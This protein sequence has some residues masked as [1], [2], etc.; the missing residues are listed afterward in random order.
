MGS[1]AQ[2]FPLLGEFRGRSPQRGAEPRD[3]QEL[4]RRAY[5]SLREL[6]ARLGDRHPLVISIDDLQWGDVDSAGLLTELLRLPDA[7]V[8]LLLATYRD[9]E[10]ET[11]P[12]MRSFL[13]DELACRP[14]FRAIRVDPLG[15][16][17]AQEL[18]AALLRSSVAGAPA[19]ATAIASESGG[20][21]F[22]IDELVRFAE[23][24]E[25]GI[26][27]TGVPSRAADTDAREATLAHMI[28]L[29]LL[30]LPT[31]AQRLL[32][33]AAVNGRPVPE[34]VL[35]SA[36]DVSAPESALALLRAEHLL[37]ARETERGV[38]LEPYHDRIRELVVRS[39]DPGELREC[40][41]RLATA[42]QHPG[43]ADPELLGEHF[44][45]AGDI[46]RAAEHL[47]IAGQQ[48]E[49]ALAFDRAARLYRR[50]L[51]LL[52]PASDQFA[53][54]M[55]K[56]G[57]ALTNAGRCAEAAAVYLA[58]PT[59]TAAE[60]I[61]FK[62]KAAQQLL[63][64]GHV[65]EGLAVV[66]EVLGSIGM[67][68]PQGR[69]QTLAALI[70][71][72]LRVRIRGLR[73]AERATTPA[74][75]DE[76]MKVDACWSVSAGLG[77]VDTMR[78]AVFQTRHL[79]LALR[80]GE[81]ARV[82]RAL[83]MEAMFAATAGVRTI[84]R[85][86]RIRSKSRD[87]TAKVGTPYARAMQLL[88][89]GVSAY[90]VGNWKP[91]AASIV[92]AERLLTNDCT[93]VTWE[94]DCARFFGLYALYQLGE[95]KTIV[96][97]LPVL[98]KDAH[99]RGDLYASTT[100]GGFFAHLTYL[101]TDDPLGASRHT[102]EA[103]RHWAQRDF[104]MPHVW[105]LWSSADIAMYEGRGLDAY[106]QVRDTWPALD[107]SLLLNVQFMRIS[108]LDLKGRAALSAATEA[109]RA[110]DRERFCL[111][112]RKCAR[113]MEQQRVEWAAG[114]ALMLRAGVH[115]LRLEPAAAVAALG[116][117]HETFRARDMNLL[118][119]VARRRRGEMTG[120]GQGTAHITE[121]DAW[122][123][124][125]DIRE[126]ASFTRIFAPAGG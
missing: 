49:Q 48:A 81:L 51:T 43:S 72:R 60:A 61:D 26:A 54:C 69:W 106:T 57:R 47:L 120:G 29:R 6:L 34:S 118:A 50:T 35:V 37:R 56:H 109:A 17:E 44:F 107:H 27:G 113:T 75:S 20:S 8:L 116:R 82:H 92:D 74:S 80:A 104:H 101:A 78:G 99:D 67:T 15:A 76:L 68:L 39:L 70:V 90:L 103:I 59:S 66:G 18:A 125:Q 83:C 38:E 91:A 30:R 117:A 87:L 119:A 42:F 58:V 121:A 89:E 65:E 31:G 64:A 41:R 84:G 4:R 25:A 62:Q 114:L 21:P 111:V 22:F 126:P 88:S 77:V 55:A 32:Q 102:V 97:R 5:A 93:G 79:L 108:M 53:S 73:Y 33:V 122:M 46:P 45:G 86:H 96:A 124:A 13:T 100:I 112:A 3:A 2:L 115:Q 110:S 40:H 94:L 9:V 10:M 63:F 85:V 28:Q 123:R 16:R 105:E 14:D 71:G 11:S 23:T 36:A 7:P 24:A 19:I 1:I 52:P 98:L 95:L 12:F